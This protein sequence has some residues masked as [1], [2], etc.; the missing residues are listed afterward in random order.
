M[1]NYLVVFYYTRPK[2]NGEY[3]ELIQKAI[4]P[5]LIWDVI[6]LLC[7]VVMVRSELGAHELGQSILKYLHPDDRLL[8]TEVHGNSAW[9]GLKDP[10]VAQSYLRRP[11]LPWPQTS[12]D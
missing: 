8:V 4:N 7:G 6:D 10:A 2:E 11:P 3:L 9:Y 5:G 12:S 1:R